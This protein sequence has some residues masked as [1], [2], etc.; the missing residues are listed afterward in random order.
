LSSR[1]TT[2]RPDS[3]KVKKEIGPETETF[4]VEQ[5]HDATGWNAPDFDSLGI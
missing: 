3:F 1:A 2:C 5:L 4:N